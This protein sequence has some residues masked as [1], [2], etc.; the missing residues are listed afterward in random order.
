VAD[1]GGGARDLPPVAGH[2]A[3]A[4]HLG[5]ALMAEEFDMSFFQGKPLDHGCFSPLSMLCKQEGG[6]STPIIPLQVGVLQ[7]PIPT[8]RRC[9][10]LGQA[11]RRA[12][13]SYPEDLTVAIVATGG[14]RTR[15][16]VNARASTTPRGT[17]ASWS[18]SNTTRSGW[19]S[20]PM[21]NTPSWAAWK[22]PRSSCG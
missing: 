1:E 10:R 14:S 13:E 12:I 9:Y 8:A 21:P 6:W 15:C 20:S 18:C 17:R 7:F 3:L 11:L 2:P 19:P 5:H 4:R 16:T 22:G